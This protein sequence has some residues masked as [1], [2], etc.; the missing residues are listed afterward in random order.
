MEPEKDIIVPEGVR[1]Y[2]YL[3]KSPQAHETAF[4]AEGCVLVGDVV[5]G[6]ESSVWYNAVLR[7]DINGVRVGRMSNVQDGCVLHVSDDYQCIVGD[8]V[9]VGHSVVLHACTIGDETTVGM[10][11]VIMN[12]A[13]V[14][15]KSIVAA[16]SVIP[17]GKKFPPGVLL[18]G[19][20][21]KVV[22][23]LTDEEIEANIKM[24]KKYRRVSLGHIQRRKNGK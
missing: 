3:G 19:A 24:A 6:E 15:E 22:R 8:R 10:G 1:I 14:G 20:P 23:D 16:G 11:S 9:T 5:I 21:A 13:E 7:G 12:A 18:R 2:E 17:I 4:L